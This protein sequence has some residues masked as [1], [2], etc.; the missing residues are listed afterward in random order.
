MAVDREGRIYARLMGTWSSVYNWIRRYD[1]DGKRV[2]FTKAAKKDPKDPRLVP[3][4]GQ[5]IEGDLIVT[6][7]SRGY[8]S[9]GL[10]FAP[11]G[12]LYVIEKAVDQKTGQYL[13]GDANSLNVYGPEGEFKRCAIPWLSAGVWG[14]RLDAA[15]NIYLTDAVRPNRPE[16]KSETTGSVIQ[17]G[18]EGGQVKMDVQSAPYVTRRDERDLPPATLEGARW[19]Y[20]GVGLTAFGHCVCSASQFDLDGFGRTVAGDVN[21]HRIKM[22]DSAGNLLTSFGEYG[23]RDSAGPMSSLPTPEIPLWEPNA[24]GVSERTVFVYDRRNNRILCADLKYGAE[25][26]AVAAIK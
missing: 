8:H 15:G 19:V 13:K 3:E 11:N 2:P 17:Y 7:P 20:Y 18:P 23:N 12:D 9:G 4:G 14:P 24:V 5:T 21:R 1:R 10:A 25:A 26:E 6:Q 22:L 16:A